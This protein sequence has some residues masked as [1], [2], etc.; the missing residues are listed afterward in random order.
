[1]SIS[2][3][4]PPRFG[5]ILVALHGKRTGGQPS[6]ASALPVGKSPGGTEA[7]E[8]SGA[9]HRTTNG[10]KLY[11]PAGLALYSLARA[12]FE[13][14]RERVPDFG[15]RRGWIV[16]CRAHSATNRVMRSARVSGSLANTPSA[17]S[18]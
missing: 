13:V 16:S 15:L 11:T 1:M 10:V 9:L 6:A 7:A 17:I 5:R 12:F 18:R 4:S 14:P 2:A 3:I 8:R